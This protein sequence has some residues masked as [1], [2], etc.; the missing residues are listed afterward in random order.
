DEF[1]RSPQPR[2]EAFAN[3][4]AQMD[5]VEKAVAADPQAEIA[6]SAADLDRILGESRIAVIHCVEGGHGLGGDPANVARL[7]GRGVVYLIV[8]HLF[9]RGAATCV[10]AFPDLDDALF[11]LVNPQP[12]G[13]A[14]TQL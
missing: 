7:R 6:R 3:L 13:V 14:P 4:L 5:E 10:N 2:P 12:D 9:Y 11:H 1:F 8:A